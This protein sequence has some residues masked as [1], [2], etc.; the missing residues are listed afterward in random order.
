[1]ETA[2]G[3]C[4]KCLHNAFKGLFVFADEGTELSVVVE[5]GEVLCGHGR[6]HAF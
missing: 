1:M 4:A 3:A 2:Y 5:E 6:V